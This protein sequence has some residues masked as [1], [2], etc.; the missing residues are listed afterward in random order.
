MRRALLRIADGVGNL[1]A[2]ARSLLTD[3]PAMEV[4]GLDEH[5]A[6]AMSEGRRDAEAEAAG[7]IENLRAALE[8]EVAILRGGGRHSVAM[9]LQA[10]LAVDDILAGNVTRHG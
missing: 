10:A 4:G 3:E 8:Q 9:R 1:A 5:L 6:A 2:C 7:R